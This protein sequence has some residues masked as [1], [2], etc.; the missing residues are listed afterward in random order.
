MPEP[1][2]KDVLDA[3]AALGGRVGAIEGAM[4]TKD[5]LLAV[6]QDVASLRQDVASLRSTTENGFASLDKEL[7]RHA[8]PL[9]R[10]LEEEV[11]E[12]RRLVTAKKAARP[13]AR[14]PRRG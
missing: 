5:E 13:A 1:T 2:L 8:D 3:I 9:H 12:L 10:K 6:R 14:R 11:A 4:A 7:A